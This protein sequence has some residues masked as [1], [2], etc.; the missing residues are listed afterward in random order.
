MASF[1][2]VASPLAMKVDS[3]IPAPP[4]GYAF[5][6]P[7]EWPSTAGEYMSEGGISGSWDGVG[8]SLR[9]DFRC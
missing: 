7:G 4:S 3:S 2:D 8:Y 9:E 6:Y 1:V 5:A